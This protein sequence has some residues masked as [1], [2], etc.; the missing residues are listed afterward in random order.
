MHHLIHLNAGHF[1]HGGALPGFLLAI[2][3]VVAVGFVVALAI[4]KS[5]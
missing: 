4:D 2:G 1:G 3:A 5:K